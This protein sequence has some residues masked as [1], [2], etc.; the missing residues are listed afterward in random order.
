MKDFPVFTSEFGAASLTLRQ[1]PYRGEAYIHLQDFKEEQRQAL[2]ADCAAFCRAAGAERIFVTPASGEPA[3]RILEMRGVPSLHEEDIENIFPVTQ[4]TVGAWRRIAN[5]CLRPVDFAAMLEKS[6]EEEILKSGGAYFIHRSG[7]L[8]GIGWL[9]EDCLELIASVVPGEG[10]HVAETLLSV[11][12][13]TGIRLEVASTNQKAI[14]LYERLG[15]LPTAEL[16]SWEAVHPDIQS[17]FL[18]K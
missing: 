10:C 4:E 13:G 6:D 16:E 7:R 11:E 9:Q 18:N 15:F 8:L 17:S 12:P 3:F 5:D 14:R 1:I 2:I